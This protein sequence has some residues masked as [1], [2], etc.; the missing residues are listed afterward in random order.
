MSVFYLLRMGSGDVVPPV[1]SPIRGGGRIYPYPQEKKK[2]KTVVRAKPPDYE[3]SGPLSRRRQLEN[4][5]VPDW[6]IE[7]WESGLKTLQT[8]EREDRRKRQRKTE[9]ALLLMLLH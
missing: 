2:R 3:V 8:L 7:K 4:T 1:E 9:A 5:A 6:D